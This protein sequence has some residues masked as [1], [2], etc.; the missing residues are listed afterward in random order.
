MD[1]PVSVRAGAARPSAAWRSALAS[2]R[3]WWH[4]LDRRLLDAV[5]AALLFWLLAESLAH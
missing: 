4:G 1:E 5:G 3:R 2:A